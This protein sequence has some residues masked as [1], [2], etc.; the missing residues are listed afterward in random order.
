MTSSQSR[1]QKSLAFASGVVTRD[2]AIGWPCW[3]RCK[4]VP[5]LASV[6]LT[7]DM[8]WTGE[9]GYWGGGGAVTATA[10]DPPPFLRQNFSCLRNFRTHWPSETTSCCGTPQPISID[11]GPL[12]ACSL[13]PRCSAS[14]GREQR[15]SEA[16][17]GR[18]PRS[19]R[20][21]PQ[22]GPRP[23]RGRKR[24]TACTTCTARCVAGRVAHIPHMHSPH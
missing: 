17:L 22:A 15:Y 11:G 16:N 3:Q 5:A 2:W 19:P 18:P 8:N 1:Q 23:N 24:L 20:A 13:F 14:G 9:A 7:R 12:R 21:T 10:T 4:V 6:M